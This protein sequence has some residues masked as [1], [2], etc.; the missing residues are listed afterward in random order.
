MGGLDVVGKI[1][2]GWAKCRQVSVVRM[3]KKVKHYAC[4]NGLFGSSIRKVERGEEK[5]KIK[6]IVLFFISILYIFV[7]RSM[8]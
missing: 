8:I 4:F 6:E 1:G 5:M 7:G 2:I 3:L